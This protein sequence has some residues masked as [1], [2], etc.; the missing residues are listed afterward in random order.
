MDD[1]ALIAELGIARLSAEN[2]QRI[3]E[4]VLQTLLLRLSL[5]LAERLT[6]EQLKCL[7]TAVRRGEA[8]DW[9][10]LT[11]LYPECDVLYREEITRLKEDALLL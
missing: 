4:Y 1:A 7:E 6:A 2:R 9:R 10:A 8:A 3:L 11:R 5:R